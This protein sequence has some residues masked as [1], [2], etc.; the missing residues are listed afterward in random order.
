[1]VEGGPTVAAGFVAAGLV[2]EVALL[3]GANDIGAG[4]IDPLEGMPLAALTEG[5]TALGSETLGPDTLELYE[6]SA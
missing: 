1:M 4:G 5:M 6:R 2:D 3:R